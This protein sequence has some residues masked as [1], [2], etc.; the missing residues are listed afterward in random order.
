[1]FVIQILMPIN[2]PKK[3]WFVAHFEI[4]TGVV[5]FYNSSVTFAHE[6]RDWYLL[7]RSCLETRLPEVLQQTNVFETKGINPATYRITFR[8]DD[9][10]PKQRGIFGDCGVWACIFYTIWRMGSH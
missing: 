1:M 7:M 6:T 8:N 3:H 4:Q 9:D 2:E 5:T 10:A